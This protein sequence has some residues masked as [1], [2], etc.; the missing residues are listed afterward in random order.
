MQTG[1]GVYMAVAIPAYQVIA[2]I[3]GG[4]QLHAEFGWED[5][6]LVQGI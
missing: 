1:L 3:T 2:H 6:M 5:K 4:L